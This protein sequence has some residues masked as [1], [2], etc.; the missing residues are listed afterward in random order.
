MYTKVAA[1]QGFVLREGW[2]GSVV[3]LKR[4]EPCDEGS[5]SVG[6]GQVLERVYEGG[7]SAFGYVGV[8]A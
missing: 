2:N 5:I 7:D 6:F 8:D 1:G 3:E 4:G